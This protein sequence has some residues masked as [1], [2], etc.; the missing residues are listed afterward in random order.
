MALDQLQVHAK[1]FLKR[2]E[3]MCLANLG[4]KVVRLRAAPVMTEGNECLVIRLEHVKRFG[5]NLLPCRNGQGALPFAS[6][7]WLVGFRV[8]M[9]R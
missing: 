4:D 3:A 8:L 9:R 2:R 1:R 5:W 7:H 6:S